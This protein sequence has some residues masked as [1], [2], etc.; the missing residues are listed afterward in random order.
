MDLDWYTLTY[1]GAV[2]AAL[3]SLFASAK[4]RGAYKRYSAYENKKGITG[5][6]AARELLE[7]AGVHDMNIEMVDGVLTDHYDP[8]TETLRL[9]RGVYEGKNIS[10]VGIAAHEAAHAIQHFEGYAPLTARQSFVRFANIGSRMSIPI[11]LIG[12]FFLSVD[13]GTMFGE[14]L[15]HAGLLLFTA[16]V[17]LSLITL[18][19]EFNASARAVA[20]LESRDMLTEDELDGAQRVLSA[21]AWT[22]IAATLSAVMTLIRLLLITRGGRRR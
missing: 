15:I 22:Y 8:H 14:L 12:I 13:Y 7:A 3:M 6:E 20:M 16:V 2:L 11:V 9:S 21:A 18:P 10:S 4:V 5:A 17:V 19:V 1:I